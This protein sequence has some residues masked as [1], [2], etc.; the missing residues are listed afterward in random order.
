V[1]HEDI[2]VLYFT[3]LAENN[4]FEQVIIEEDGGISDWHEGFFDQRS[5]DFDILFSLKSK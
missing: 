3:N 5:N 1:N 4:Y 2:N